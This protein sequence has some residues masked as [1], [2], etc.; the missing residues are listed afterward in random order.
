MAIL[1]LLSSRAAL[2]R[3]RS[4]VDDDWNDVSEH[5]PCP[6]CG[7]ESACSRRVDE[8][9]VS[10]AHRPSEWPLTN[11]AWLHRVTAPAA[12]PLAELSTRH[13]SSLP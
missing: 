10:C 7:G 13:A 11:G 5:Q 8:A 4:T 1:T 3:H 2:V 6:I 12:A 9:F